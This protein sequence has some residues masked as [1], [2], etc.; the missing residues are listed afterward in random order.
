MRTTI[1]LCWSLLLMSCGDE[2]PLSVIPTV[3]PVDPYHIPIDTNGQP[4]WVLDAVTRAVDVWAAHGLLF[5][6]EDS[7]NI[8]LHINE[9][10]YELGE[11]Y[12]LPDDTRHLNVAPENYGYNQACII[13]RE[14]GIAVNLNAV[15]G[16]SLM[17]NVTVHDD[18]AC[19]WSLED[20]RQ[21]CRVYQLC[22]FSG[23][24]Q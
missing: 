21:L 19:L 14:L 20:Q 11:Y 17:G 7:G 12:R 4:Q 13:A 18:V 15:P 1:T 5:A 2:N 16:M 8:Y 6:L 24:S 9:T 3:P 23:P 22:E 10:A